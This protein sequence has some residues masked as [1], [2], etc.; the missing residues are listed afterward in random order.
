MKPHPIRSDRIRSIRQTAFGW[1]DHRLK[2]DGWLGRMT[3]EERDLYLF[4]CLAADERG[5]SWYAF[6]T[7]AKLL[8]RDV[9]EVRRASGGL[10]T[11]DL[12]AFRP[13][14]AGDGDGVHQ[15]LSMPPIPVADA[16]GGREARS[17]KE[18]LGEILRRADHGSC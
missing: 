18:I 11:L 3:S 9:G 1:L 16:R 6:G 4:L 13:F 7:I 10:E 5:V 15:V 2:R 14:R 17:T 12:V 8:A